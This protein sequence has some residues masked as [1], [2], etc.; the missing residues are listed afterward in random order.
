MYR[1]CGKDYMV[2]GIICIG[3]SGRVGRMVAA[4]WQLNPSL[5]DRI[6]LQTRRHDAT[7]DGKL[8]RWDPLIGAEPLC[9]WVAEYG[10][11]RAMIVL[12][13]VTPGEGKDLA[14]NA[15]IATACISAATAARIPRVLVA[16]SSAVYGTGDG[17]GFSEA[18]LCKPVNTYGEAKVN[19]ERACQAF[20]A[21]GIDICCLRI[22]N[23]AGADALL[24]NVAKTAPDQSIEIDIFADGRGPLRSYIGARTLAFVLDRLCLHTSPLPPVLNVAAP[25]PIYMEALVEAAGRQWIGRE[26]SVQH[27]QKITLNCAALAEIYAFEA[28][29]SCPATMVEHW[30]DTL[31]DDA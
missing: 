18:S 30:R 4:T 31:A 22:G 29:D 7:T 20:A 3:A 24:L 26:K 6:V 25:L 12:A 28:T 5:A 16:S 10:T 9:E 11:P 13:G 19:M 17:T 23:V 1:P 15:E 21:T 14:L 8:L 2:D 27:Y